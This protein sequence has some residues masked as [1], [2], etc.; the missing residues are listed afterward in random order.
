MDNDKQ[1]AHRTTRA[2]WDKPRLTRLGRIADIAGPP[3]PFLQS[4]GN[5]HS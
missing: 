4:A 3:I 1:S 2:A 5:K